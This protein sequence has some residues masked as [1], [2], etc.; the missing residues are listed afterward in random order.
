M[1][2]APDLPPG[3]KSAGP[4]FW[5]M[6]D[7]KSRRRLVYRSGAKPGVASSVTS[8]DDIQEEKIE[9][10]WRGRFAKGKLIIIDGDP[11]MGKSCFTLDVIGR[12]SRGGQLPDGESTIPRKVLIMSSED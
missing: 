2:G 3:W 8:L 11:S 4:S 1:S 7:P 9:W 12:M 6:A 10:Q 5:A